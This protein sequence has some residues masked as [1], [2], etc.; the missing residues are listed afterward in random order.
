VNI[1]HV[2]YKGVAPAMVKLVGGQIDLVMSSITNA[3][4]LVKSGRVKALGVTSRK[5]AA[6]LPDVRPIVE[7]GLPDY[8]ASTW[9]GMLAP[10]D[11]PPRI[12]ARLNRKRCKS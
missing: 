9:Y 4:P 3:V 1:T 11:V 2:P 7:Q 8:E 5:R 12:L 6:V 10:A